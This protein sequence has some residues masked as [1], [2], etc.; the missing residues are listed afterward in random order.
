MG[1]AM[2]YGNSFDQLDALPVEVVSL[3]TAPIE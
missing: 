3:N 1:G 2:I